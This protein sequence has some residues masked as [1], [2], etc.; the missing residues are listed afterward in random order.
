MKVAHIP[1][2]QVVFAAEIENLAGQGL[3]RLSGAV[4]LGGEGPAADQV[5]DQIDFASRGGP[6]PVAVV[7]E[8]FGVGFGHG[9]DGGILDDDPAKRGRIQ[10]LESLAR[11]LGEDGADDPQQEAGGGR[12]EAFPERLAAHGFGDEAAQGDSDLVERSGAPGHG[13]KE[14]QQKALGGKMVG[15]ALDETGK[16]CDGLEF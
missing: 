13:L 3:V 12:G 14:G 7:G 16:S 6:S 10:G 4:H 11:L 15:G 9:D 8:V 5:G 1:D 2:D